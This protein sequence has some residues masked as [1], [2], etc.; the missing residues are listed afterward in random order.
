MTAVLPVLAAIDNSTDRLVLAVQGPG[1]VATLDE[2][3]AARAS[4]RLLPALLELLNGAGL[5]LSD[6]DAV[7][8]ARG[9]GAFTGLRVA[10]A[11]AQGL[12][13]G[14]SRPVL[15]LDSLLLVAE[16][17]RSQ[18]GADEWWVAMDARM[19]E[20]YAAAYR[21]RGGRWQTLQ[22]PAL[23]TLDALVARWAERPPAAVAGS[24]TAAFGDRL[25]LPAATLRVDPP[26]RAAALMR[27]AQ[28]AWDAGGGVDP[29]QALPLYLRDKVAST[30]A[31]RAAAAG[32]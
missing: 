11:T 24:A 2:P 10:C 4:A 30:T 12:A 32:R 20:V 18:C 13:F 27:L 22:A 31:E 21:W 3:G 15:P 1:G 9:P 19:D 6:L 23:W 7:A 17:A 14:L 5:A 16:A 26:G 28:A 8:F 29:A 25:P